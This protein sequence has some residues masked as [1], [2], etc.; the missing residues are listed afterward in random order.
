MWMDSNGF[1]IVRGRA[2]RPRNRAICR[3]HER[4]IMRHAIAGSL[5]LALANFAAAQANEQQL[6][7]G[8]DV[9]YDGTILFA[10][11]GATEPRV[12]DDVNVSTICRMIEQAAE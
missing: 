6:L 2:C 11:A 1:N 7:T 8:Q 10:E 3:K 5:L 4:R 9:S 12:T